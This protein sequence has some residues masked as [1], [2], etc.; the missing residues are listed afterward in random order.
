MNLWWEIPPWVAPV[1]PHTERQEEREKKSSNTREASRVGLTR[2]NIVEK[3]LFHGRR[4]IVDEA[5]PS[6]PFVGRLQQ[7]A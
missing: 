1:A 7:D 5:T 2:P 3:V 4:R 6:V